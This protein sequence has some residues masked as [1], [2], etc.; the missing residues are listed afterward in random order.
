[1]TLSYIDRIRINRLF[2]IAGGYVFNYL[3]SR[4]QYNKTTTQN[5]ILEACKI[6]IYNDEP[7]KHLSQ[8]KCVEY[9]FNKGTPQEIANL[10]EIF[11]E[12]YCLSAADN[13][14]WSGEDSRDYQ[15][16]ENLIK[17]LRSQNYISLPELE[18][19]DL[20]LVLKEVETHFNEGTPEI[21]I[22]RLHTFATVYIRELCKR[23]EVPTMD[24]K[25]NH[26]SLE[27]LVGKLSKWYEKEKCFETKFCTT[28]IKSTISIFT[29]F[30]NLRN[31]R[32]AAH[33]NPLLG[34]IEAEYAIKVVVDTL[35]FIDNIE[36]MKMN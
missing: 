17:K 30:N 29:E 35:A 6:D 28:A 36:K 9:I 21:V 33:P 32:S 16:V 12:Y 26:Y 19:S 24:E 22:D 11:C 27:S 10:L 7:Y 5:L 18:S 2:G 20:D 15:Y 14:W 3:Q 31:N 34:K 23:H 1:M 8:Q 4:G 13:N 25:G